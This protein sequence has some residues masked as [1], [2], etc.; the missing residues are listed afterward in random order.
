M[1]I[2]YNIILVSIFIG[3]YVLSNLGDV[4]VRYVDNEVCEISEPDIKKISIKELLKMN[5]KLESNNKWNVANKYGYLGKYQIG[6]SALLD[7]G[8]DSVWVEE[9]RNSIYSVD[10]TVLVDDKIKIRNFYYF[11][12]TLF[13][14]EKQEEV[15]LKLLAKNEKVY[16][17]KHI[18][19]YV[20][21]EVGGVRITKAGIL[22]ASFLGFGYVDQY[23][24]S[25]GKINPAD[26]NGHTIKD[27]LK[28]FQNYELR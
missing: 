25:D 22:S 3:I 1:K 5:S 16:L 18:R 17:K 13:P 27:R 6:R 26:G 23:L 19:K 7:L 12:L 10:D 28:R 4:P 2:L 21:K 20:G 15:I 8:Y 24:K 9:I 11:D 14:P